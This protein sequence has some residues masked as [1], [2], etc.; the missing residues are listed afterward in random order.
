MVES[1]ALGDVTELLTVDHKLLDNLTPTSVTLK[2]P[3]V[4]TSVAHRRAGGRRAGVFVC[5]PGLRS[6]CGMTSYTP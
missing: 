1:T 2:P 3:T 5:E 6:A 4:S